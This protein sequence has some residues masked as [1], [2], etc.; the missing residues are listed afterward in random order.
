MV[1]RE[2]FDRRLARLEELLVMLRRLG[3]G[4]RDI[5][6]RDAGLQAQAER[7]LHLAAS[8]CSTWRTI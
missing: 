7:W 8:A 2:V 1:D 5:Y 3:A 4:S 6:L